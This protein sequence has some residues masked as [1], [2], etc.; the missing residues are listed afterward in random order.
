MMGLTIGTRGRAGDADHD[1][2]ETFPTYSE[3]IMG[4]AEKN[5]SDHGLMLYI[6]FF[7]EESNSQ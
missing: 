4:W 7:F 1:C 5:S 2:I 6:N 3:N